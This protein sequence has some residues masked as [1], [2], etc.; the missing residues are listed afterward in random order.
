MAPPP[1]SRWARRAWTARGR[2]K[3]T[4]AARWRNRSG[5]SR[6]T[7]RDGNPLDV[8]LPDR[9][10]TTQ[11]ISFA[12][13]Y[14]QWMGWIFG[15]NPAS[16]PCLHEMGWFPMIHGIQRANPELQRAAERE[17]AFFARTGVD[18]NGYVM[19]RWWIQGYYKVPW[20]NLHDQIPHFLLAVYYHAVS[21]RQPGVCSLA[22][23]G[24][25]A[26]GAVHELTGQRWRR[27]GRG[28]GDVRPSEREARMFQL[29]RHYQ[30]RP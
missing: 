15:N 10:L 3:R 14:N 1:P 7:R 4:N 27:R 11:L 16:T 5:P 17:L 30:V 2:G 24:G 8:Q 22:H 18:Q 26:R 19:P 13:V 9:F 6:P 12:G 25:A 29:V 28:A 21:Y 20:G 23:A